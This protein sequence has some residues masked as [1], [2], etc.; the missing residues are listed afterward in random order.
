MRVLLVGASGTIGR[1]VAAELDARHEIVA[2]GRSFGDVSID[3]TDEGSIR[4]AFEQIGRVDAVVSAT[5]TSSSL[6]LPR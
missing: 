4:S 2:A 1:A 5:A 6:R 3:I